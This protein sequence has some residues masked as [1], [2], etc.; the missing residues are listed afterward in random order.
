MKNLSL[1]L[2]LPLLCLGSTNVCWGQYSLTSTLTTFSENFNSMGTTATA[3]LP[4]NWKVSKNTTVRHVDTFSVA[5]T[6]TGVAGSNN[7]A[8]N[9]GNGIYNFGDGTTSTDRAVGGLSSST[10]SK[11]VNIFTSLTNS[12]A[13]NT[14][15]SLAIS[16]NV[17]KYRNGSNAAGFV[18]QLYY[19]PDGLTWTPAGADFTT[20][21]AADADN[22]G[23]TTA[24]GTITNVSKNFLITVAP[25]GT[26][27]LAWNY[28]VAS[29][30]TTTNAQALGIDDISVTAN[31]VSGVVA[32]PV[33]SPVAGTYY[34]PQTVSISTTTSGATIYYTTDGSTPTT[35]STQYTS[36]ISLSSTTTLQAIAIKSGV[37]NSSIGSA[38]YTFPVS[39]GNHFRSKQNG[40]WADVATWEYSSDSINWVGAISAPDSIA[41]SVVVQAGHVVKI[42]ANANVEKLTVNGELDILVSDTL[43]LIHSTSLNLL[44]TNGGTV[45]NSGTF[46]LSGSPKCQVQ[47][48]G[49]FIDNTKTGSG[50]TLLAAS[51]LDSLSNF[52]Y[53]GSSSINPSNS[54]SNRTY[55][56]L[57]F[58]SA[59]GTIYN[60]GSSAGTSPL[61]VKG[62][63]T[64]G[65]NVSWVLGGYT[66]TLT[67]YDIDIKGRLTLP[68]FTLASGRTFNIFP[69]GTLILRSG[70]TLNVSNGSMVILSNATGTGSV[71]DSGSTVSGNV[72]VQRYVGINGSGADW[73]MIGFPFTTGTNIAASVFSGANPY[74][75]NETADDGNNYSGTGKVGETPN[76]GW[77]N[78]TG[79][80]SADKGIL[81]IGNPNSPTTFSATGTL[82][83]GNVNIQLT[84]TV[85]GWNF[86]ANPYASNIS[87][88][89]VYATTNSSPSNLDAAIYRYNPASTAYV[90]YLSG[91]TPAKTGNS[92][93]LDSGIIENGAGFFVHSTGATSLNFAET[94]EPITSVTSNLPTASL[95]G[96]D[97]QQGKVGLDGEETTSAASI[98]RLN[99]KQEGDVYGDEVVTLWG[100]NVPATDEFDGK[101]DAY[102]LGRKTGANLSVIDDKS[103]SYSIFH[104]SELKSPAVEKREVELKVTQLTEGN[105]TLSASIE[106]PISNSNQLSIY[107]RYLNQYTLLDENA[108]TYSFMVTS[109][110]ASKSSGRFSLVFNAKETA[111]TNNSNLPIILLNNPT[112][113]NTFI[114]YSKNN[115]VQL[116]Y[117]L[118]GNN[119]KIL[120]ASRFNNVQ[121]GSVETITA[122][123]A[124]GS[125]FIRLI[126]DN[127]SLPI[128][129]AIKN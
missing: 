73:R 95:F 24:P 108:K 83:T 104:G 126:G 114:L 101:Y 53:R 23:F 102:D 88:T 122:E 18:I 25:G 128:L 54:F 72:T 105:Y 6:A 107:D 110:A 99:L 125:Y 91:T 56:N 29:G 86:I 77:K 40:N 49:T 82:N 129:K 94:D 96:S 103:V 118:I 46:I 33:F 70:K 26:L 11:S 4:T 39:V 80:I 81:V 30:S 12:D 62:K 50:S 2:F 90:S 89:H 5:T 64:V 123:V 47:A 43:T 109:D 42:A 7:I 117:Q 38:T 115:Y 71:I 74:Y 98:V 35:S 85:S 75:F 34:V 84:H 69:T 16:Y 119:G 92:N 55:G 51:T 93:K 19:S 27:Y 61:V 116:Q 100:G 22:T 37:A 111:V 106:S 127:Q 79:N 17:E 113:N 66:G 20:S 63:L 48:G 124:A 32:T 8:T 78:L 87:W 58:E 60:V 52:I 45:L 120:Q 59:D 1:F 121:K 97:V 57:S 21:F 13:L 44:I 112:N 65:A 31:F 28:S 9:A 15:N 10:A 68:S 67:F 41:T 14:I 36:A 3:T 76:A